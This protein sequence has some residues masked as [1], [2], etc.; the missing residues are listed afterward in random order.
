MLKNNPSVINQKDVLRSNN[1]FAIIIEQWYF[2]NQEESEMAVTSL[3]D[4]MV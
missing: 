3:H 2:S 1:G 4:G